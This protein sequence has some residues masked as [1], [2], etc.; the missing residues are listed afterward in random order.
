MIATC[1]LVML[2]FASSLIWLFPLA[3]SYVL[4]IDYGV[5]IT[6]NRYAR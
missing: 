5:N 1:I 4:T 2:V 3:M 6:I